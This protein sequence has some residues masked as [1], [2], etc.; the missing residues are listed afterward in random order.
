M[1]DASRRHSEDDG[2]TNMW[3]QAPPLS[4]R[5]KRSQAFRSVQ[6]TWTFSRQQMEDPACVHNPDA[7]F[8]SEIISSQD[9]RSAR[10]AQ[11]GRE[12]D[13]KKRSSVALDRAK[14]YVTYHALLNK[15]F[16]GTVSRNERGSTLPEGRRKSP[17][18]YNRSK[19]T[20]IPRESLV[21]PL[22]LLTRYFASCTC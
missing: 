2:F 9:A 6:S 18:A 10:G 15:S 22:L 19:R 20:A 3:Y 16:T 13:V 12:R 7:L 4:I 1:S 11:E 21:H 8:S 17:R 14:P 5:S